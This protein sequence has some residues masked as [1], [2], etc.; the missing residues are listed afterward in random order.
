MLARI[1]RALADPATGYLAQLRELRTATLRERRSQGVP[2]DVLAAEAGVSKR[3][4]HALLADNARYESDDMRDVKAH[5]A[6]EREARSA[7]ARARRDAERAA[8]LARGHLWAARVLAGE[9]VKVIAQ[10]DGVPWQRVAR[11]VK[12]ARGTDAAANG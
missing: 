3:R 6:A 8:D 10:V 12:I 5:L 9:P 7:A 11:W 2:V 1:D 4:I